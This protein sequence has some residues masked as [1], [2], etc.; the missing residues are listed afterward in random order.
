ML[1]HGVFEMTRHQK[2]KSIEVQTKADSQHRDVVTKHKH[3][4]KYISIVCGVIGVLVAALA[5]CVAIFAN[6]TQLNIT[7]DNTQTVDY[8]QKITDANGNQFIPE[9]RINSGQDFSIRFSD[10]QCAKNCNNVDSVKLNDHILAQGDYEIY[11]NAL[12]ITLTRTFMELLRE[13]DYNLVI[14]VTDDNNK[15]L[16]GVRF[17]VKID[18]VDNSDE[19]MDN[20]THIQIPDETVRDQ[21][22]N[23]PVTSNNSSSPSSTASAPTQQTQSSNQQDDNQSQD[24]LQ[25]TIQKNY[26]DN[27]LI[28]M[29]SNAIQEKYRGG[30]VTKTTG[31]MSPSVS[32]T[33]ENTYQVRG[34]RMILRPGD[35]IAGYT[36]ASCSIR[37]GKVDS[38]I[39]R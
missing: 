11:G 33:G 12:T 14:T 36:T 35:G 30:L 18:S 3:T 31:T 20:S 21:L 6:F 26:T 5:I 19:N 10:I 37:N 7:D 17:T 24:S 15:N 27:E 4:S 16:F 34:W 25:T 13:G 2:K 9:Y 38:I 39:T 8:D 29:C 23:T 1:L 28:W 22:S 32:K